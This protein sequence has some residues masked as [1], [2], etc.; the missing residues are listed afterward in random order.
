M[1]TDSH[2]DGGFQSPWENGMTGCKQSGRLLE[3][4]EDNFPSQVIDSLTRGDAMLDLLLTK[5]ELTGDV[6]IGEIVQL[7]F[8]CVP[9]LFC[10]SC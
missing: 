7:R 5:T 10:F 1:L 3:C 2:P 6:K 8:Y 4:T 9:V